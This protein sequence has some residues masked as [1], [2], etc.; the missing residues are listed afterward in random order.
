MTETASQAASAGLYRLVFWRRMTSHKGRE[1]EEEHIGG[2]QLQRSPG[3]ALVPR[4][5]PRMSPDS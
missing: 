3:G 1:D 5:S 4:L 2:L